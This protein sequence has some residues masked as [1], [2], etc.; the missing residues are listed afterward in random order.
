MII[1]SFYLIGRTLLYDA[2]IANIRLVRQRK[3]IGKY[4]ARFTKSSRL[5]IFGNGPHT[6]GKPISFGIS[7]KIHG[8]KN[9]EMILVHYGHTFIGEK[10]KKDIFTLT[11]KNG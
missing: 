11:I 2:Q 6:P 8:K 7:I 10:T 1:H 5:G 3:D 4:S 9:Q